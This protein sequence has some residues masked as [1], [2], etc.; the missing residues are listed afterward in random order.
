MRA[1]RAG[2]Q[3]DDGGDDLDHAAVEVDGAAR[4][5]LQ[6]AAG[7]PQ[8]R[9]V[10]EGGRILPVRP[11]VDLDAV[12]DD[13]ELGLHAG[14]RHVQASGLAETSPPPSSPRRLGLPVR[15]QGLHAG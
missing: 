7:P 2:R 13:V 5:K 4:R 14:D 3:L 11:R 8:Q 10:D 6:G 12:E 9:H 1:V 15:M